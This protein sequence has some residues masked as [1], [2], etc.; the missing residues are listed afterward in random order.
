MRRLLLFA[1]FIATIGLLAKKGGGDGP[2][3]NRSFGGDSPISGITSGSGSIKNAAKAAEPQQITPAQSGSPTPGD[4]SGTGPISAGVAGRI[5]L[6]SKR[7]TEPEWA[8]GSGEPCPP[9]LA[10]I[11]AGTSPGLWVSEINGDGMFAPGRD[12]NCIDC[13]RAVESTWRGEGVMAAAM[14]DPDAGLL[15]ANRKL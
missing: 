8:P 12:N 4:A 3:L 15:M 5:P 9:L 14:A 2:N 10:S 6:E 7:S 13:S 1:A 11:T